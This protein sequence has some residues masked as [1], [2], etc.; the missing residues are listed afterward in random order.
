MK[1]VSLL[2][3][4]TEILYELGLER[5]LVGI[6]H[7]CDFPLEAAV[8]P[9]VSRPR[10][11]PEGLSSGE[12]DAAVRR[13]M[14]EFGSVYEVDL[15]LLRQLHP[16]VVL[17]QALCEVCAV[18]TGSVEEAVA[19]LGS[20]ATVVSLDAHTIEE[21]FGTMY[22][23]AEAAGSPRAGDAA[24]RRLRRRLT[25]VE[26]RVADRPRPRT[27][28]LEWL[29]P[30]FAPGHW[31]PEMVTL[32]GG[33]NLTGRAGARSEQI[34]WEALA[35]VDPDFLLVEP[36]GYDLE[37]GLADATAHRD[38]LEAVAG[39]AI[40]RGRAWVLHSGWFSRSGPRV[41]E[42]VEALARILHPSGFDEFPNPSIARTWR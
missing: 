27:L 18:P 36:C 25:R 12:I 6:S 9:R 32:A 31:V 29:D 8:L 40:E 37:L 34:G 30:P 33:D 7:E 1:I 28:L 24:I 38:R 20:S 23:V 17:T 2:G 3:S 35:G 39:Q 22:R 42:G 21:I 16:D 26:E 11:A 5:H 4:A 19:D 10:F 41:V 15:D 14:E 13:C